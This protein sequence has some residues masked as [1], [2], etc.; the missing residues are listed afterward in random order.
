MSFSGKRL[1][2]QSHGHQQRGSVPRAAGEPPELTDCL[3]HQAVLGADALMALS[4]IQGDGGG[5]G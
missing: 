1:Q 5:G 2:S 4:F 3:K